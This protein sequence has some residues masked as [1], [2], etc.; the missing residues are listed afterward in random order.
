MALLE[1]VQSQLL[2]TE[3]LLSD[4]KQQ[5]LQAET[6]LEKYNDI[7]TVL[8]QEL[9]VYQDNAETCKVTQQALETKL[10]KKAT[11]CEN[12]QNLLKQESQLRRRFEQ[13]KINDQIR[14]EVYQKLREEINELK[15]CLD[16]YQ[17]GLES[18]LR[19]QLE[20]EKQKKDSLTEALYEQIRDLEIINGVLV[21]EMKSIFSETNEAEEKLSEEDGEKASLCGE[22]EPSSEDETQLGPSLR[23]ADPAQQESSGC[24]HPTFDF[25]FQTV[26]SE[27][28]R[29]SR[30]DTS[31]SD[32]AEI[33]STVESE[34]KKSRT[35]IDEL[36]QKLDYYR[37]EA[38]SCNK[39]MQEVNLQLKE[40]DNLLENLQKRLSR[41]S[42]L[43]RSKF[44]QQQK[45][46]RNKDNV[47]EKLKVE[48]SEL[49]EGLDYYQFN[50]ETF[51]ITIQ[52]LKTQL[53]ELEHL[54]EDQQQRLKQESEL[55][56]RLGQEIQNK[57]SF[58]ED[59]ETQIRD[60]EKINHDLSEQLETFNSR[61]N[62]P[63]PDEKLSE[64]LEAFTYQ[65][66]EEASLCEP[67][68]Q[69]SES[70]EPDEDYEMGQ[71]VCSPPE[72]Q[73]DSVEANRSLHENEPSPKDSV[74][75]TV[76]N[77]NVSLWRRFKKFLT[78]ACLRKHKV[79]PEISI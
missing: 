31:L 72:E 32:Q 68:E 5:T 62:T 20:E 67:Q 79:R 21:D 27:H 10:K 41:E 75:Q 37:G 2:I 14:N 57:D 55:K 56:L 33:S 53:E 1:K 44:D 11:V 40:K 16:Y 61:K 7:I 15:E 69:T 34:C 8:E 22:C 45:I 50:A 52:T 54:I 38:E 19:L 4:E 74:P 65:L 47:Y 71:E 12:L 25:L 29:L 51:K 43:L 70:L 17:L 36:K 42:E 76:R 46:Q 77:Q 58:N 59:L 26:G 64:E 66:V 3:K 48:I 23:L 35:L 49:E 13:G 30:L 28:L 24:R 73:I 63:E 78:P 6:E 60:L 18:E 39:M 9:D